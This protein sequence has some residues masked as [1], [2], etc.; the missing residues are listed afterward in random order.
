[1]NLIAG[2]M[3]IARIGRGINLFANCQQG[4]RED[5][6][7]LGERVREGGIEHTEPSTFW[8]LEG[9]VKEASHSLLLS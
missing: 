6:D 7:E 9:G 8:N 5:M 3:S 4:S 1:M 2:D